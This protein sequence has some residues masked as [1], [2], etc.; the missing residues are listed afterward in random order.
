MDISTTRPDPAESEAGAGVRET[1]NADLV[2][3]LAVNLTSV[4]DALGREDW[5]VLS[6]L[7]SFDLDEQVDRWQEELNRL[8]D[9]IKAK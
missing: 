8:A 9:V 4:K 2:D 5:P 6:D 3:D 7:L 1:L